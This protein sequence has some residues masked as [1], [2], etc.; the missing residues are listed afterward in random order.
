[1]VRKRFLSVAIAAGLAAGGFLPVSGLT[2]SAEAAPFRAMRTGDRG[3]TVTWVQKTV[4]V[5]TTGYYGNET[6]AGVIRFQRWFRIPATGTVTR[7]TALKLLQVDKIKRGRAAPRPAPLASNMGIRA[8][9]I[10]ATQKGKPYVLGGNGPDVFD[11]S[12]FT[13]FVYSRLGRSLPRTTYQQYAVT[14]VPRNQLRPGDLIFARDLSHV[15]IYAGY[16]SMW[17]APHAGASVR[18]QKVYDPGYLVGRVR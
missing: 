17:S 4:G 1:M 5:R 10:A 12:G 13:R 7:P 3:P 14:K 11:C 15:G 16:G 8:I 6:R 9:Q 2:D 18:L